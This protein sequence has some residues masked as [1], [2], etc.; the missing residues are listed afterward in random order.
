[1]LQRNGVVFLCDV[2]GFSKK[3]PREQ[4]H[5]ITAMA[6]WLE[7]TL[8]GYSVHAWPYVNSTGDGFLAVFDN[9]AAA[10]GSC[11]QMILD[12]A[13]DLLHF[14][15]SQYVAHPD[16]TPEQGNLRVRIALHYGSFLRPVT[17]FAWDSAVGTALNWA[18]RI[19]VGDA[20][21]VIASDDFYVAAVKAKISASRF[22]PGPNKTPPEIPAKHGHTGAVY[23]YADKARCPHLNTKLPRY[24]DRLDRLYQALRSTMEDIAFDVGAFLGKNPGGDGLTISISRIAVDP[25]DDM[26]FVELVEFRNLKK[27]D[28]QI[29]VPAW[30]PGHGPIY[31]A[32]AKRAPI[33]IKDLPHHSPLRDYI[34]AV[35]AAQTLDG[36][37][38]A[39]EPEDLRW[40]GLPL[41]RPRAYICAPFGLDDTNNLFVTVESNDPLH[42]TSAAVL[43]NCGAYLQDI[44]SAR[45]APLVALRTGG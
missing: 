37:G 19:C 29:P 27:G 41:K 40:P 31:A 33:V 38:I 3:P 35:C 6:R 15:H 26:E 1:M 21:H 8:S 43:R 4:A 42:E 10:R 18:S 22:L 30:E 11:F 12:L 16:A 25:D 2:V 20:D 45:L 24:L 14:C 34:S 23:I 36:D 9:H 39:V 44:A 17:T 32:Q 5:C 7:K 13:R 28:R